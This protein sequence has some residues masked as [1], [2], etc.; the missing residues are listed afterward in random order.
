MVLA[1]ASF[2]NQPANSVCWEVLPVVTTAYHGLFPNTP[3]AQI[4]IPVYNYVAAVLTESIA[5][6]SANGQC[7]MSAAAS[8][9]TTNPSFQSCP[10]GA[11]TTLMPNQVLVT[12]GLSP[13]SV[14]STDSTILCEGNAGN[15]TINL[16]VATGTHRLLTISNQ[17]LNPGAFRTCAV[18]PSGTDTIDTFNVNYLMATS[19]ISVQM[20]DSVSGAWVV[21]AQQATYNNFG[22][23]ITTGGDISIG[24]NA[25]PTIPTLTAQAGANPPAGTY[26]VCIAYHNTSVPGTTLCSTAQSITTSGSNNIQVTSPAAQAGSSQYFAYFSTIGNTC[27][28]VNCWLQNPAGT[29]IGTNYTQTTAISTANGN[30]PA[31]NTLDTV[32]FSDQVKVPDVSKQGLD[33]VDT[34]TIVFTYSGGVTTIT[35]TTPVTV[36]NPTINTDTKMIEL[37]LPVGYF[38]TLGQ[39]SLI[40]AGGL[41]SNTAATSPALT[42]NAK[43]CTVSGCGSGIVVGLAQI[44]SGATSATTT[45]NNTWSYALF[46]VTNAIGTAG[47]LVVKA[48]PGLTID[49]SNVVSN[50]DTV[51]TDVNTA[52][53][54]NI[55]L[56]AALFLDFTIAQSVAGA[57]NSYKQLSAMI[58]PQVNSNGGGANGIIKVGLWNNN[59][60]ATQCA[61]PF[62]IPVTSGQFSVT[63]NCAAFGGQ[64]LQVGQTAFSTVFVATGVPG[65]VAKAKDTNVA[66]TCAGACNGTYHNTVINATW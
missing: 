10:G 66:T 39:G 65:L 2:A 15:I 36:S 52:A 57:S 46:A 9:A 64:G 33:M 41:Y 32:V 40:R 25:A 50:P 26:Q 18:H 1:L 12:D 55:D 61:Q 49:L 4:G 43:L 51:Y 22:D 62:Y 35:S 21:T 42:F 29:N 44:V 48:D 31:T 17:P 19:Q 13:Y 8:F 59:N 34:G 47:N 30:T 16:P 28:G 6:P 7:F 38:N 3:S 37:A 58:A 45:T 20:Y 11:A 53:S 23:S 24:I 56:T 54:S 14:V 5:N 27:P 60:A 63:F